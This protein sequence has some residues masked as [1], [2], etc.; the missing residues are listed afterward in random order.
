MTCL[1]KSVRI[2][3]RQGIEP[4]SDKVLVSDQMVNAGLK[5]MEDSGY[6][7]SLTSAEKRLVT[8]VLEAA[9][10]S[11]EDHPEHSSEGD[12]EGPYTLHAVD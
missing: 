9:L 12:P 3:T 10:S 11:E 7:Y 1:A 6:V 5:A 8:A 4:M 2:I